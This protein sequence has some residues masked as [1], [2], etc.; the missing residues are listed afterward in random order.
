MSSI[1]QQGLVHKGFR[2]TRLAGI[3]VF[4]LAYFL[5]LTSAWA[6]SPIE[7][8]QLADKELATIILAKDKGGDIQRKLG[9]PCV[10][11]ASDQQTVSYVYRTDTDNYLRFVVNVTRSDVSYQLVESMTMSV[12]PIIQAPCYNSSRRSANGQL[13]NIHTGKG[14]KL[15]ESMEEIL[16]FYG[17]PNKKHVNGS[18]VRLRY[19]AGFDMDRYYEWTLIFRD[20][21]LVEW[22]A[23]SIPF[24]IEVG[25]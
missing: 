12:K 22:T 3:T 14:I 20:G 4:A 8:N 18:K 6:E 2:P 11:P 7:G 15:G 1:L 5:L 23:E 24:F 9:M 10:V 17:E 16:R 13:A 19:D 21:W 25:G